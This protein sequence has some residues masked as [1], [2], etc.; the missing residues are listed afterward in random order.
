[1]YIMFTNGLLGCSLLVILHVST[2]PSQ[3]QQQGIANRQKEPHQLFWNKPILP[4]SIVLVNKKYIFILLFSTM[5]IFDQVTAITILT[6]TITTTMLSYL[7]VLRLEFFFFILNVKHV[8]ITKTGTDCKFG[9][10]FLFYEL[11][12]IPLVFNY[13][14]Q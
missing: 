2:T 13:Y 1:M 9:A 8:L 6:K 3:Q 11:H 5:L 10:G 7:H 14:L 12:G 4:T